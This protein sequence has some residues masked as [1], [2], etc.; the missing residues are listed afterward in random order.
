M[1]KV[2]LLGLN[3]FCPVFETRAAKKLRC[4]VL[5]HPL[6]GKLR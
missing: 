3:H 1:S 4:K 6:L 5:Y 2:Q